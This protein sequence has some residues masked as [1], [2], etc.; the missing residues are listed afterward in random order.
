[1][2]QRIQCICCSA[3]RP[4]FN[5]VQLCNVHH[6]STI[7]DKTRW[8]RCFFALKE[9]VPVCK[10]LPFTV[11]APL[12]PLQCRLL[13]EDILVNSSMKFSSVFNIVMGVGG[14][15]TRNFLQNTKCIMSFVRDCLKGL[16]T[17]GAHNS[18][19]GYDNKLKFSE[20]FRLHSRYQEVSFY[21]STVS[22]KGK[23]D[24]EKFKKSLL[25][26]V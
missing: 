23:N 13:K 1:M 3:S 5:S 24:F 15:S 18:K 25:C 26:A 4:N 22:R 12:P 16:K 2:L 10:L 11:N 17:S 19:T 20:L 9:T 6:V 7:A 8:D 21:V 14:I